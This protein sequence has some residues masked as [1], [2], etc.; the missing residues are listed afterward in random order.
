MAENLLGR[1]GGVLTCPRTLF[2]R[3]PHAF[4]S[5][6][7][8]SCCIFIRCWLTRERQQYL[9]GID[10]TAAKI[11]HESE[12][13]WEKDTGSRTWVRTQICTLWMSLAQNYA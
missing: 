6:I 1:E 13:Q 2:H 4:A 11:R 12:G 9:P 5:S 3:Y 10:H 8:S 7:L